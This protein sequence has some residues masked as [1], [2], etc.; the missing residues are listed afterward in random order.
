MAR[1]VRHKWTAEQAGR[2]ESLA[3]IGCNDKDIAGIEKMSEATLQR[4]Y[5]KELSEGRAKGIG[6]VAA[7]AYRV[8]VGGKV[9]A[10][11]MFFLKC[12]AGWAET[13]RVANTSEGA[14][15]GVIR[16][17][18]AELDREEREKKA[19]ARESLPILGP[20]AKTPGP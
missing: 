9:P 4:R 20:G 8:A 2:V 7:T 12:R 1:P 19:K 15:D 18:L 6:A 16:E 3:V 11:T 14:G 10:M 5:A 13:P 17:A